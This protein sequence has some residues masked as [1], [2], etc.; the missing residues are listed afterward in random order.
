[1]R[2]VTVTFCRKHSVN[3]ILPQG[4]MHIWIL[5][6]GTR[7]CRFISPYLLCKGLAVHNWNFISTNHDGHQ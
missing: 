6:I 7:S 2:V 1:M 5:E 4:G 3:N